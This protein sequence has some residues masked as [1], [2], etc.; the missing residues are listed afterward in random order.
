MTVDI[1]GLRICGVDIDAQTRCAHWHAHWDVVA[2]R[3]PCCDTYWACHDCHHALAD[4]PM[5]RWPPGAVAQ[6]VL[7]GA[8]GTTFDIGT[9]KAVY[10]YA[11]PACPH[12]NHPW[13]PGCVKH[14]GL[15][16]S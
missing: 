15:Y 5:Q 12:C 3:L 11:A 7:C 14:M 13:N 16:F 2:I 8:C 4:H 10:N 9:Y 6:A 1:A